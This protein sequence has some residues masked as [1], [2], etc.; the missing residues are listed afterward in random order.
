VT[1]INTRIA[2]GRQRLL[3][4]GIGRDEAALDARLLAQAV[5][6]WDTARVLTSGN[7][8]EPSAFR[9]QYEELIA[10]RAQREPLAYITGTREFWNLS[11]E[12]S[13]AV[14]I[15]RPETEGLVEAVNGL[16]PHRDTAFDI[17]DICTGSGCVAVAIAVEHPRARV[18]ASD[19]SA[20]AVEIARRNIVRHNVGDR[21]E[22]V[23]GDLVQ[24][25]T[26][27]CDVIVANPPY[28]PARTRTTLQP[29]V[30]NSEPAMALFGGA[31]GLDMIR[32]LLAESP[33]WLRPD[34]YLIFEFGDGQEDSVSALI[35]TRPELTMI[36][37]KRDL[38]GIARIAIARRTANL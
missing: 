30:R 26:A 19:L 25:L 32:R 2:E 9:R 22:C 11:F 12:V 31:D 35:S 17:A 15:P 29:E 37:I 20:A 13:P 27:P 4:A 21:V 33:P 3:G 8:L 34:G 24:P 18:V 10:R 7:E 23:Q 28:V 38:L 14:L 6:G 5:L 1:T 16:F 36:G